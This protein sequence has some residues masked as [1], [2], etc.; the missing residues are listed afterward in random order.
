MI[1][2][3]IRACLGRSNDADIAAIEAALWGGF[4]GSGED[5]FENG[6]LATG[7]GVD[8]FR[9]LE[10]SKLAANAL[11][12]GDLPLTLT[13]SGLKDVLLRWDLSGTLDLPVCDDV[14]GLLLGFCKLCKQELTL[15][16]EKQSL[17][18]ILQEKQQ[19]ANE[20][21]RMDAC[22]TC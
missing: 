2:F 12:A 7:G 21:M 8:R 4:T 17:K 13:R 10:F 6:F 11:N 16:Q 5:D 1:D 15:L 14:V 18:N 20:L 19:L 22:A 3:G 9:A